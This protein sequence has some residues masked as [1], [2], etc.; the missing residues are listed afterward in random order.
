MP[1]AGCLS[2]TVL[3]QR[4]FSSE[5]EGASKVDKVQNQVDE[6]KGIMVRN[7]GEDSKDIWGNVAYGS[8]TYQP[9][10]YGIRNYVYLYQSCCYVVRRM[11]VARL[12]S[13]WSAAN[14]FDTKYTYNHVTFVRSSNVALFYYVCHQIKSPPEASNWSYSSI[15][16]NRSVKT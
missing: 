2:F 8:V 11:I 10:V 3:L 16:L 13:V 12:F 5:N 4:H 7:I 14:I 9:F 6:L 15:K 1:F